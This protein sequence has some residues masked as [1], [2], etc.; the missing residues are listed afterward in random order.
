MPSLSGDPQM[1]DGD[2]TKVMSYDSIKWISQTACEKPQSV[3]LRV[4]PMK[5]ICD[6]GG[7]GTARHVLVSERSGDG[8]GR[9]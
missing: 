7:Q 9:K 1:G 2:K 4:A 8:E 6:N 5:G 3:L